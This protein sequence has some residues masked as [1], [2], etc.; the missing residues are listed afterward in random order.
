MAVSFK[1]AIMATFWLRTPKSELV[2]CTECGGPNIRG[3]VAQTVNC[4]TC[5][6]TGYENYWTQIVLPVY[7]SPRAFT[8]WS[9][10]RGGLIQSGESQIK[11][12]SRHKTIVNQAKWV[13][14]KGVD[15]T[16]Q[17]VHEPGQAMNQERMVLALARK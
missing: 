13:H 7:Y 12:D 11:V 8:R 16:F 17:R 6:Q 5:D 1:P 2:P 4:T 15:W 9:A 14:V 10:D 3:G